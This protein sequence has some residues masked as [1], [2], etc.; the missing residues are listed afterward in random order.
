MDRALAA[1]RRAARR[2]A[3]TPLVAGLGWR[4]GARATAVA[5]VWVL[6]LLALWHS[7]SEWTQYLDRSGAWSTVPSYEQ[8]ES[9]V[10]LFGHFDDDVEVRIDPDEIF[11]IIDLADG[12]VPSKVLTPMYRPNEEIR[13]VLLHHIPKTSGAS[14]R[15][16]IA[17]QLN[18]TVPDH[19][20]CF[21]SY[22]QPNKINVVI[23][24]GE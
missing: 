1:G 15:A 6:G 18:F 7:L 10:E 20:D 4:A 3:L 5:G 14:L 22:F 2:L 9:E 12:A 23:F 19:E 17:Q 21:V 16:D 11:N 13:K 24:R 8:A